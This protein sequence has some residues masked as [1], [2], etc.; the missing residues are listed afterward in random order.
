M[1]K[2]KL[3]KSGTLSHTTNS[4]LLRMVQEGNELAWNKFYKQ[5]S[6][7]IRNIGKKRN[8]TKEECEDLMVDVMTVFW[9]KMDEFIYNRSKGK[10]RSYM[11]KIANFCAIQIFSRGRNLREVPLETG[12]DYPAE[13]D[14][15]IM[16]QYRDYLLEKALNIL[17]ENIDT[18]IYQVFYM[19]FV[20]NRPIAEISE[21]T[22]RTPNN[23]YVIRSRCLTKLKALIK[24][25]R[26]LDEERFAGHSQR[27]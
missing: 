11:G 1:P 19:S 15:I 12:M 24:E 6:G 23:I 2:F 18:E 16:E 20:Q 22:R 10:F 4:S 21:L 13:L 17:R 26:Q 3:D 14:D 5:Y 27:K 8:L 25:F 7:L 9:R